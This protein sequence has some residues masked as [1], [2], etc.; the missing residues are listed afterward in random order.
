MSLH[1][2]LI[3]EDNAVYRYAVRTIV[4]WEQCGFEVAAEAVNGKHALELLGKRTFDLVLTDVSMPE[5]NGISLVREVKERFPDTLVVMLSSYDDFGFVKDSL[6]LG[7]EDYLLKQELEPEALKHMLDQ[8]KRRLRQRE[9]KKRQEAEGRTEVRTLML[10]MWL[11]G[12]SPPAQASEPAFGGLIPMDCSRLVLLARLTGGGTGAEAD[13]RLPEGEEGQVIAVPVREDRLVLLDARGSDDE[14]GGFAARRIA[15]RWVREAEGRGRAAAVG[16]SDE[17]TGI[18]GLQAAYRSAERALFRT[19]YEG[20][21]RLLET[22]AERQPAASAS[23]VHPDADPAIDPVRIGRWQQALR[24][25][26]SGELA[27][28]LA[29]LFRELRQ[30][31]PPQAV[32]KQHLVDLYASLYGA[33][34]YAGP[35]GAGPQ[36]W[37]TDLTESLDRLDSLDRI[38]ERLSAACRERFGETPAKPECRKEIRLALAYIR[39][40]YAEEISVAE[41][42]RHLGFSPNYLSNLFRSETGMRV[43]E[44]VNRVRMEMAKRLLRNTSLKVYEV[45]GQVGYQETSYFCK[46]FKEV[47]GETVTAFRRKE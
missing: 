40:H 10:K 29:D 43:T 41:L 15:R 4:D 20:W 37:L 35:P 2:A 12:E 5:M 7:A 27:E 23:S 25:G 38:E 33:A 24:S 28:A 46:V 9:E 47:T 39:E 45:A 30:R 21:G 44:Y 6:K 14:E 22:S 3:V 13:F 36:N 18:R 42:S 26:D 8:M 16:F 34:D 17:E 1:Q 19:V 32:L 11:T 31:K